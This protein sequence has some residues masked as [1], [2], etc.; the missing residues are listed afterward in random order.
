MSRISEIKP[1]L[2]QRFLL[3]P[4]I[5][6]VVETMPAQV[7]EI[8]LP[9]DLGR[10][11]A[12]DPRLEQLIADYRPLVL[13]T[14][15]RLTGRMEDAQDAAQEVFLR[16]L[17]NL[18]RIGQD[19]RGWLYR[20]TVNVCNDY[21][22]E[23]SREVVLAT[24]FVSHTPGVER[25][26]HDRDRKRLLLEGLDILTKAERAAI[27]LRDI[28]GLPTR[29]VAELLGIEEVTVR[30]QTSHARVKLVKYV[31]ARTEKRSK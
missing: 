13:R 12:K 1:L 10:S 16:V 26:I 8:A 20:V 7:G 24:D 31:R 18:D 22:R 11:T 17:Q 5:S 30:T 4:R 19:P 21:Y 14:A 15:Y 23:R 29:E 28:E 6:F 27:V 2:H 25:D 9:F 3:P